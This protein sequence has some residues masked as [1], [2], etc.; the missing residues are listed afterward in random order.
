MLSTGIILTDISDH[1]GIYCI[2][3]PLSTRNISN[4]EFK[5]VRNFKQANIEKF[6]NILEGSD[7]STVLS[8]DCPN[9]AYERFMSIYQAAYDTSF[10]ELS[11][12][13]RSK[14]VRKQPC[15]NKRNFDIID[16]K[17]ETL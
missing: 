14:Y 4:P 3:E 17:R 16:K 11:L 15:F 7:F 1:F 2:F 6:R 10:P 5:L 8:S 13:V 12:R 9:V